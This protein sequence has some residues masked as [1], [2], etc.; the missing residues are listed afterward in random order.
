MTWLALLMQFLP[1]ILEL[2]K[3]LLERERQAAVAGY[4]GPALAAL[5]AFQV[6]TASPTADNIQ[7]A[8]AA[9]Q[10]Y[11]AAEARIAKP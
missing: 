5:K 10:A 7:G 4:D 8:I 11:N 9:L 6:A 3:K 2:I 1:M